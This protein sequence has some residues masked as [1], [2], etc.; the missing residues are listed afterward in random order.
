MADDGSPQ[1]PRPETTFSSYLSFYNI[2]EHDRRVMAKLE[3]FVRTRVPNVLDDFYEHITSFQTTKDI[4]GSRS[5]DTLKSAQLNHWLGV[6]QGWLDESYK[7]RIG[8]IG[9]AH[10]RI[11]LGPMWYCGGYSKIYTGV[12]EQLFDYYGTQKQAKK[13]GFFGLNK[14]KVATEGKVQLEDA[15]QTLTKFL[16]LDMAMAINSYSEVKEES[17]QNIFS[18]TDAF[19]N[20]VQAKVEQAAAAANELSASISSI[21]QETQESRDLIERATNDAKSTD[22]TVQGLDQMMGDISNMVSLIEDV[23][24]QINL[25]S[26]NAA[27]ESARAGEAGRGFAVVA[28]EVRKLADRTSDS[29]REIASKVAEIQAA[30]KRSSEALNSIVGGVEA[31]KGRLENVANSLEEQNVATHQISEGVTELLD[32]VHGTGKNIKAEI[33]KNS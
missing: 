6:C 2:T 23:S 14:K 9:R 17:F 3:D 1:T 13:S 18:M 22:E 12:I 5:T 31:V 20:S 33:D 21:S 10:V 28:D 7:K 26:L 16:L 25:L 15:L 4:I 24:E 19:A 30:S 27:I 32:E 11:G 29:T 8:A